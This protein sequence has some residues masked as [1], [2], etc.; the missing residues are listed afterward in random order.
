MAD[1]A[2]AL[3]VCKQSALRVLTSVCALLQYMQ[4]LVLRSTP[5]PLVMSACIVLV[6]ASEHEGHTVQKVLAIVIVT[7]ALCDW[8][9]PLTV[10][11][12]DIVCRLLSS[13]CMR[14][15]FPSSIALVIW[16]FADPTFGRRAHTTSASSSH[17][18]YSGYG[19]SEHVQPQ[20]EDK[21]SLDAVISKFESWE[22]TSNRA[23]TILAAAIT[24]RDSNG[25]ARTDALRGM[26]TTWHVRRYEKVGDK[27]NIAVSLIWRWISKQQCVMPP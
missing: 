24:L 13:M 4:G 1:A 19:A 18:P 6:D 11:H 8:H 10:P 14:I 9:V 3:Q 7:L 27:W 26:S 17:E 2:S 16:G 23:D 15:L 5:S 21:T 20:V 22:G 25:R 12:H